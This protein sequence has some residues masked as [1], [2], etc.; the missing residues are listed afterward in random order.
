MRE[1]QVVAA[2]PRPH[3]GP[4]LHASKPSSWQRHE[5]PQVAGRG[6]KDWLGWDMDE[7]RRDG[8]EGDPFSNAADKVAFKTRPAH[9]LAEIVAKARENLR[10]QLPL[11]A[12]IQNPICTPLSRVRGRGTRD[13]RLRLYCKCRW[14]SG[15]PVHVGKSVT[16]RE[17]I[18]P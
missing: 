18:A 10:L 8:V 15:E 2:A 4:D 17:G 12:R 9:P 1:P 6:R 5:R 16:V 13:L 14:R 7:L 11:P 3:S